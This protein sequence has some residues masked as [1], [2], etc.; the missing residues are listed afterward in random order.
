MQ[1]NNKSIII[2][3]AVILI[4]AFFMP[5][6][7]YFANLSAWDMVL[8]EASQYIDTAFK[9][10]ALLIP[11]AGVMIIYAAAFNN[12]N[13]PISK[14]I[15]FNLPILTL[16]II[17]IVI[18]EKVS[19][20]GG[21]MNS[22]DFDN[23][24][25]IFGIGFW[26]TLIASILLPMF[27]KSP[28]KNPAPLLST[29]YTFSAKIGLLIAIIGIGLI[30]HSQ[31]ANF[32][33]TRTYDLYDQN[34]R[35]GLPDAYNNHMLDTETY[36]DIKKKN[37]FLYGGLICS[38]IGGLLL[39]SSRRLT[40]NST[41][42]VITENQASSQ[43]PTV[44][45]YTG[46]QININLPKVN[47]DKTINKTKRFINKYKF[48]LLSITILLIAFILVY[49]LFIK[50]DPVKDGKNLAKKYCA[51]SQEL[52]ESNLT[53]MKSFYD[54][55][56]NKKFKSRLEAKNSLTNILQENQTKYNSCVQ[57]VDSKYQEQLA[58]YNSKG[59]KNIYTFQ[60]TYSSLINSCNNNNNG[61]ILSSRNRIDE[62]IRTI[63]DPEPNGEKIKTDLIG[64]TIPGWTFNYLSEFQT[65]NIDNTIKGNERI[66]YLISLKLLASNELKPHDAQ[67]KIVYSLNDNGWYIN[68][69]K[70][71]FIT[72]VNV[73][74]L[75]EWLNITPLQNCNYNR[76][77][78]G[79]K[80][81]VQDP[82]TGQTIEQGPDRQ[83]VSLHCNNVYIKSRES[84]PVEIIFKY[85]P[86]AN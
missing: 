24:I 60:Q 51:C 22:S 59:G 29:Q 8:G 34:K 6:L 58:N 75:N 16:V 15:L 50:A 72:Y 25:Q 23:L 11:I 83:E 74:P 9:Y 78:Q 57:T 1:T 28:A 65:F 52:N 30:I 69:L 39:A 85:F 27:G 82:C 68:E 73:A 63:V 41:G 70:E 26:L 54:E 7:K 77:D 19:N 13:Y 81:Y 45:N 2:I 44:P 20:N 55:F 21:R 80:Y 62:K 14:S 64:N 33:K 32:T 53:S 71:V 35:M 12:E 86:Q 46:P 17:G 61:D 43:V 40:T 42:N 37:K 3:I 36:I 49:N 56:D 10:I 4:A 67:I 5:W 18:G 48:I 76:I 31:T 66:E 79:H 84:T 47:W 38:I